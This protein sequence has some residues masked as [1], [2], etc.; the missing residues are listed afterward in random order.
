MNP[1]DAIRDSLSAHIDAVAAVL[2]T[3]MPNVITATQR[4]S[5]C[6]LEESRIFVCGN[7]GSAINAQHFAVKMLGRLERERPGLP[8]FCLSENAA[9]MASLV[10]NYGASDVF[11]R[12]LRALGQPG[13]VLLAIAAAGTPT[14]TMQA[15]T[16]AHDREMDVIVLSGRDSDDLMRLLSDDDI[17]IR[18]TSSSSMRTEEIHF[19]LINVLSDMLERE[20]FGDTP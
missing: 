11:A 14:S 4:L 2:E 6:L 10:E 16:A 9:L 1:E 7:A 15:I 3:Q 5:R 19:L 17:D 13:D 20:L 18:V 12:Q 8:V